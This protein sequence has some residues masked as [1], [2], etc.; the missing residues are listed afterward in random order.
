MKSVQLAGDK[1]PDFLVNDYF[2]I[3]HYPGNDNTTR[4]FPMNNYQPISHFLYL[5]NFKYITLDKLYTSDGFVYA[6]KSYNDSDCATVIHPLNSTTSFLTIECGV[7]VSSSWTYFRIADPLNYNAFMSSYHSNIGSPSSEGNLN[8][9]RTHKIRRD[10]EGVHEENFIHILDYDTKGNYTLFFTNLHPGV[11][12]QALQITGIS[13]LLGFS[14]PLPVIL[15]W[16][17]ERMRVGVDSTWTLVETE[18]VS[19][20]YLG[21]EFL[22]LSATITHSCIHIHSHLYVLT[23]FSLLF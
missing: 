22:L 5:P 15:K 12:F 9:W 17:I 7:V 16:R 6:V 19:N 23:S 13:V 2:D 10:S 20:T 14:S 3:N 21:N 1:V 18:L 11:D 8:I 4:I